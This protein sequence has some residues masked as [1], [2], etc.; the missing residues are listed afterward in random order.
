MGKNIEGKCI[1][2][3]AKTPQTFE[4]SKTALQCKLNGKV[5]GA[6]DTNIKATI[7]CQDCGAKLK[8]TRGR[9]RACRKRARAG[10][11]AAPASFPPSVLRPY[12]TEAL[13][14]WKGDHEDQ[15]EPPIH[16][17]L[18]YCLTDENVK[19]YGAPGTTYKVKYGDVKAFLE[20]NK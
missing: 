10:R 13:K 15:G 18:T 12:L 16:Q 17:F 11:G 3:K 1:F 4:A 5:L 20:K 9:T 7:A 14:D 8:K 19:K 2:A 6:A